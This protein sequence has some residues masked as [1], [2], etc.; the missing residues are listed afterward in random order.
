MPK[1]RRKVLAADPLVFET[2]KQAAIQPIPSDI[3]TLQW[4]VRG[5]LYR[6]GRSKSQEANYLKIPIRGFTAL[7]KSPLPRDSKWFKYTWTMYLSMLI[8][9]TP[10]YNHHLHTLQLQKSLLIDRLGQFERSNRNNMALWLHKEEGKIIQ[11]LTAFPCY[12]NYATSFQEILVPPRSTPSSKDSKPLCN[13]NHGMKLVH[14]ILGTLHH[15]SPTRIAT[16]LKTPHKKENHRVDLDRL[17]K[18]TKKHPRN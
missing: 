9:G 7:E 16:L 4:I 1:P 12:C 6:I 5:L 13:M 17:S 15:L 10:K 18:F 3:L 11:D 8:D 14:L 2:F